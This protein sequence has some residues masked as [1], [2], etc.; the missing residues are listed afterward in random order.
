MPFW[1]QPWG[2]G[3]EWC[4]L[5]HLVEDRCA[6]G[7]KWENAL[8]CQWT[9]PWALPST[10]R[11]TTV[12]LRVHVKPW[13]DQQGWGEEQMGPMMTQI[14][15]M[16]LLGKSGRADQQIECNNS[17]VKPTVPTRMV[18]AWVLPS[19]VPMAS[20]LDVSSL[21]KLLP[22]QSSQTESWIS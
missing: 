19:S 2:E 12:S 13:G 3:K 11:P 10:P 4:M 21:G 18:N 16:V 5:E 7:G 20:T 9:F 17:N 6:D 1:L 8:V 22:N 14:H 15:W